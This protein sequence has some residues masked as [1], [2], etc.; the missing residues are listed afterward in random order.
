MAEDL[1]LNSSN[2]LSEGTISDDE[3][4]IDS[5]L[6]LQTSFFHQY[7]NEVAGDE[8]N[9]NEDSQEFSSNLQ[10]LPSDEI[11][12]FDPSYEEAE[13]QEE[14]EEEEELTP[15]QN[16][17]NHQTETATNLKEISEDEDS[18]DDN[19]DA[20]I[21]YD[22]A[23]DERKE[24]NDGYDFDID[25][26]NYDI[27]NNESNQDMMETQ[28]HE[29]TLFS[30]INVSQVPAEPEIPE[31]P[32]STL[33]S[34]SPV[35]TKKR[36]RLSPMKNVIPYRIPS[37]PP[38]HPTVVMNKEK[39]KRATSGVLSPFSPRARRM[40]LQSSQYGMIQAP[41]SNLNFSMTP[42]RKVSFLVNILPHLDSLVS[43]HDE[44]ALCLYP[45]VADEAYISSSTTYASSPQR[46]IKSSY[47]VSTHNSILNKAVPAQEVL[48]VNPE[49]F[50]NLIPTSVTL[51]TARV[52]ALANK[53]SE[54]WVR[55]YRFD[56]V[57]WPDVK[58]LIGIQ[59]LNKN[60]TMEDISKAVVSDVLNGK[61]AVILGY[62]VKNGGRVESMFGSTAGELKNDTGNENE[63]TLG[64]LEML[65]SKLLQRR[66]LEL[67]HN[68]D[69]STGSMTFTLSF[70]EILQEDVL[71]DLLG[72]DGQDH[73]PLKIRHPDNKGAIVQ[74]LNEV[75]PDSM[76]DVKNAV[77][78]AFHGK[79]NYKSRLMAGGRGHII[80]TLKVYPKGLINNRVHSMVQLVDLACAETDLMDTKMEVSGRSKLEMKK[81]QDRRAAS[82]RTSLSGLGQILR[83]LVIQDNH[84]S[85]ITY[86][87]CTLT[88]LLQRSIESNDSRVTMI[89]TVCPRKESYKRTLHTLTFIH[90]LLVR[91]DRTAES[92]FDS[93][94]Q[95]HF[96]S[97]P[98]IS[99]FLS[100]IGGDHSIAAHSIAESVASEVIRSEFQVA[101]AN[102]EFLKSLV[103]DPRQRLATLVSQKSPNRGKVSS[104]GGV[105]RHVITTIDEVG[106]D[107][108][109][110]HDDS[111]DL[112]DEP[113]AYRVPPEF[114]IDSAHSELYRTNNKTILS[115]ESVLHDDQL[116]ISA[117][118]EPELSHHGPDTGKFDKILDQLNELGESH[119]LSNDVSNDDFSIGSIQNVSEEKNLVGHDLESSSMLKYEDMYTDDMHPSV[120]LHISSDID[121][122]P[123]PDG[124]RADQLSSKI[125]ETPSPVPENS[126]NAVSNSTIQ[127]N[128]IDSIKDENEQSVSH[129]SEIS[130]LTPYNTSPEERLAYNSLEG[131]E[132]SE[133]ASVDDDL[134]DPRYDSV[135]SYHRDANSHNES[136]SDES[137]PVL[138]Q[139][140]RAH[141]TQKQSL[142]QMQQSDKDKD[143]NL[144]G[145]IKSGSNNSVH[146][147]D[148]EELSKGKSEYTEDDEHFRSNS[149]RDSYL[150]SE[151]HHLNATAGQSQH[152]FTPSRDEKIHGKIHGT[153][154]SGDR[155][156][157]LL[158]DALEIL[159]N[160]LEMV[161][162][163][164]TDLTMLDSPDRTNQQT[165]SATFARNNDDKLKP[166]PTFTHKNEDVNTQRARPAK[167]HLHSDFLRNELNQ[168]HRTIQEFVT[169]TNE[170]VLINEL[171][172]DNIQIQGSFDAPTSSVEIN[173]LDMDMF[174][175]VKQMLSQTEALQTFVTTILNQLS[176]SR[177]AERRLTEQVA[178]LDSRVKEGEHQMQRDVLELNETLKHR[179]NALKNSEKVNRN[180]KLL[181]NEEKVNKQLADIEI[182]KLEENLASLITCE[183]KDT[184]SFTTRIKSFETD[185]A[186]RSKDLREAEKN[187][188]KLKSVHQTEL[189]END[190][191]KEKLQKEIENLKISLSKIGDEKCKQ[192]VEQKEKEHIAANSIHDLKKKLQ[193]EKVINLKNKE[194]EEQSRVQMQKEVE[195]LRENIARDASENEKANAQLVRRLSEVEADLDGKQRECVSLQGELLNTAQ[196][197][198]ELQEELLSRDQLQHESQSI[199]DELKSKLEKEEQSKLQM[200]KEVEMLRE[201]IARDASE[202]EKANAQLVRRLSE[203]EADLD[204]KQRECVSLQ[205]EL[206]RMANSRD[207]LQHESQSIQDELKSKL[208]K[209]EQ[210]KLQ[211][212]KE[213]EMLRENI[214][215]LVRRL[216][217]VEVDVD[218]KQ[219]ECVSLK[220]ELLSVV[221]RFDV[222]SNDKGVQISM[223][224]SELDR[225]NGRIRTLQT[226]NA[227]LEETLSI[228]TSEY[229][230]REEEMQLKIS[231]LSEELD[232]FKTGFNEQKNASILK[233]IEYD[234]IHNEL[235]QSIDDKIQENDH[236]LK[237]IASVKENYDSRLNE[238][239]S[240]N[241]ELEHE[242]H[243]MRTKF[244][245]TIKSLTESRDDAEALTSS[246]GKDL[247]DKIL[248]IGA[249]TSALQSMRSD[250]DSLLI[251]A[252]TDRV[253]TEK[254]IKSLREKL[255]MNSRTNDNLSVTVEALKQNSIND[256]EHFE[257][258]FYEAEAKLR[259]QLAILQEELE[260]K[261]ERNRA[262]LE[263]I[264]TLRL[265]LD[266]EL[267][268]SSESALKSEAKATKLSTELNDIIRT[269]QSLSEELSSLR[270]KDEETAK[271]ID[272]LSD[273]IKSVEDDLSNV[274][275]DKEIIM[276]EYENKLKL[277]EV[278]S[279]GK[280][281]IISRISLELKNSKRSID[282]LNDEISN[283]KSTRLHDHTR[284][285]ME[286][287]KMQESAAIFKQEVMNEVQVHKEEKLLLSK[288]LQ[289][290]LNTKDSLLS[291]KNEIGSVLEK[292]VAENYQY[293]RSIDELKRSLSSMKIDMEEKEKFFEDESVKLRQ[294][295]QHHNEE[296]EDQAKQIG[297][298]NTEIKQLYQSLKA[299]IQS[300]ISI[301]RLHN[302]DMESLENKLAERELAIS[303]VSKKFLEQSEILKKTKDAI[304]IEKKARIEAEKSID[305]LREDVERL[306]E[307]NFSLEEE[308][309]A[310]NG[311]LQNKQSRMESLQRTHDE[312]L[313]THLEDE[314][315]FKDVVEEKEKQMDAYRR[316]LKKEQ[317]LHMNIKLS[318]ESALKDLEESNADLK[319]ALKKKEK[320]VDGKLTELEEKYEARILSLSDKE[321]VLSSRISDLALV[322][323]TL[324]NESATLQEKVAQE[325]VENAKLKQMNKV[326]KNSMQDND[327]QLR[328]QIKE[329][330]LMM[331]LHMSKLETRRKK[332][333]EEERSKVRDEISKIE[334]EN[335]EYK[336]KVIKL[337][338]TIRKLT[339]RIH[340]GH[341]L[342]VKSIPE[343][344]DDIKAENERLRRRIRI[345]EH[346]ESKRS[347]TN[348]NYGVLIRSGDEDNINYNIAFQ[349]EK[350][351][352]VKA[353]EFAAAMAAR[354]KAGIEE[355]NEEIMQLRMKISNLESRKDS[356]QLP[357]LTDGSANS[358][359]LLLQERNDALKE[360]KRYKDIARKLSRQVSLYEGRQIVT[361][362]PEHAGTW[363]TSP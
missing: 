109:L 199:Q 255:D 321:K 344:Y 328:N 30:P 11:L 21:A 269:N 38:T 229:S 145:F 157:A 332:S 224:N 66:K 203:V 259:N 302:Q 63:S 56:E 53:C 188:L 356:I 287:S 231:L 132:F 162:V 72:A 160:E 59:K 290:L 187:A 360:A 277:M 253:D 122:R 155:Y 361:K 153:P 260:V 55:K 223:L 202:N 169:S 331:N 118:S 240:R 88:K 124:I 148:V 246:L 100:P 219:R 105:P 113:S 262:L 44:N 73:K 111:V 120:A 47:S 250:Y 67:K 94:G 270:Q 46:S 266:D 355:R 343:G 57:C 183:S 110:F 257:K 273:K 167:N 282:E 17:L 117:L 125:L 300:K 147:H 350:D 271:I 19:N 168:L 276:K 71:A 334:Q 249:L 96:G 164:H 208:E 104:P 333:V 75:T 342:E 79:K 205:D 218:G 85:A 20:S 8:E 81:I 16:E 84:P 325:K 256:R 28:H 165:F 227:D 89:S 1:S 304:V 4:P 7:L 163:G 135:D 107:A 130:T 210:S 220:E 116:N 133:D 195:M 103:Q 357:M 329:L 293:Q 102:S 152:R 146:H 324:R 258:E 139:S 98:S 99:Q 134:N 340:D 177:K 42:S 306:Q 198:D 313:N 41:T 297:E 27:L 3:N 138:S 151:D 247:E 336:M 315:Q 222:F 339:Q 136:D 330:E 237:S 12:S 235:R 61:N 191:A 186:A 48:L 62:G 74:D 185:L 2:L 274:M 140:H 45:N 51:E 9:L 307:E 272:E 345:L 196:S 225:L 175:N 87:S 178:D 76:N 217:E 173:D 32:S 131:S 190:L 201:N 322:N 158:D 207:Q 348:E 209:E 129:E 211:M 5:N 243:S 34:R 39:Q 281:Q 285:A 80:V 159:D 311:E 267:R 318:M 43:D 358:P 314:N 362:S 101:K 166:V 232:V 31:S 341:E 278:E 299:E 143:P 338:S 127:Q 239:L 291:E 264:T 49:A 352:R 248:Q 275:R 97:S 213:V 50:G 23:T 283:E 6:P 179:E 108:N 24:M 363:A 193:D 40:R 286:I 192:E 233:K 86:R 327:E 33:A 254:I 144:R 326:L 335:D 316:Q 194:K 215:Q 289:T 226:A 251:Y 206:L 288:E 261:D 346:S 241:S 353:E 60:G 115:G 182:E 161:P 77:K 78:K 123:D 121:K 308:V 317:E 351:K 189:Q 149:Q 68:D 93:K 26:N 301:E 320:E 268:I 58:Q 204:G 10:I 150:I 112:V 216:S 295:I 349:I 14:E 36:V 265:E 65:V 212:Q 184:T 221:H 323:E 174:R 52:V 238:A 69:D 15:F 214:A 181:L 337:E 228:T 180:L 305:H 359:E 292:T 172:E 114:S 90:R 54:D 244:D 263:N 18:D 280:E 25:D 170:E 13:K 82:I 37:T 279:N 95:E 154:I 310:L 156:E 142:N 70:V 126:I 106:T 347:Q 92:P 176:E 303:D 128:L 296:I 230:K 91:P 236:L 171:A 234:R 298:L 137:Y 284:H 312:M 294:V 197:R 64:F 35:P 354:A 252:V 29:N 242:A 83:S 319:Q 309:Q 141:R 119:D 245:V 200:Q 22:G